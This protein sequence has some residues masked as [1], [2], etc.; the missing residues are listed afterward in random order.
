MKQ[1]LTWCGTRA[2]GEKPLLI[3]EDSNAVL[4]GAQHRDLKL[5]AMLMH[6]LQL[7]KYNHSF[8]RTSPQSRACQTGSAGYVLEQKE[9]T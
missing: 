6:N 7:E 8:S 4:A 1:L 2:L 9:Y 3:G 5:E